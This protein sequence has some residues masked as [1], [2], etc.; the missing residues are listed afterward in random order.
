[1]RALGRGFESVG[2]GRGTLSL[3]EIRTFLKQDLNGGDF[4]VPHVLAQL[5]PNGDGQV[6]WGEWVGFFVV[7]K[8]RDRLV[9]TL[10]LF[11]YHLSLFLCLY[12]CPVVSN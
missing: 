12:V 1:M 5:D 10:R 9:G 6:T 11:R 8:E 2:A 4:R 3:G 7:L